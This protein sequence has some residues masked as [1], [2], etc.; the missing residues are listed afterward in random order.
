MGDHQFRFVINGSAADRLTVAAS[1]D[2]S[3]IC[4]QFPGKTD[5]I[6]HVGDRICST[7][8]GISDQKAEVLTDFQPPKNLH[9]LIDKEKRR[10]Q[11]EAQRAN[12]DEYFDDVYYLSS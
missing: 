7:R 8:V 3:K 6:I 2:L 11:A 9:Q 5:V 4:Q 10:V 12:W 1:S